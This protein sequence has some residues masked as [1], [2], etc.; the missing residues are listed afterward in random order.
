METLFYTGFRLAC[1]F[2]VLRYLYA[3][4]GAN[5]SVLGFGGQF[6]TVEQS[7]FT[8]GFRGARGLSRG[9]PRPSFSQPFPFFPRSRSA[10]H[11]DLGAMRLRICYVRMILHL[12]AEGTGGDVARFQL[13]GGVPR[14][15]RA[16]EAGHLRQ[17]P[18]V[19]RREQPCWD[20]L[21]RAARRLSAPALGQAPSLLDN[22]GSE[23]P[24]MDAPT[25]AAPRTCFQSE[26]PP[27]RFALARIDKRRGSKVSRGS[28][29]L[30]CP[31]CSTARKGESARL[32]GDDCTTAWVAAASGRWVVFS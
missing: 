24:V 30:R 32:Q 23:G 25:W 1:V 22:A 26:G 12:S 9:Y 18:L 6:W 2:H 19:L 16:S 8:V 17:R 31:T 13:A 20:G 14:R 4:W 21:G 11:E 3:C 27:H 29:T 15:A 5:A 7:C 28:E 10:P